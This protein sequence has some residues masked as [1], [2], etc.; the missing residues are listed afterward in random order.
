[1]IEHLEDAAERVYEKRKKQAEDGLKGLID[2]AEE[3]L[4]PDDK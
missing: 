2:K 4:S 1:M 3:G